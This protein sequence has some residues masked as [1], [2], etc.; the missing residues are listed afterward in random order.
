MRFQAAS[1]KSG[2]RA[3]RLTALAVCALF[4]LA[5]LLSS[6]YIL[7]NADHEHDHSGEGGGCAVCAN[8]ATCA[9]LI[10]HLGAAMTAA[11]AIAGMAGF[12]IR[13]RFT[14]P[15]FNAINLVNLKVRLNI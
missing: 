15:Q 4:V 2:R 7:A 14:A 12:A 8:I 10:R 1:V 13:L 9:K 3:V 5:F 11:A 6:V